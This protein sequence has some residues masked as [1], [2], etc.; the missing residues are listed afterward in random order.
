MV[1]SSARGRAQTDA[2]GRGDDGAGSEESIGEPPSGGD[3]SGRF[4]P[5]VPY[6]F[7]RSVETI[8]R[9]RT[10][11]ITIAGLTFTV[12]QAG[13]TETRPQ[14]VVRALYQ[15]ILRREPDPAG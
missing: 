4:L 7:C 5:G 9:A 10:A 2:Q 1:D 11:H 15:T 13:S 6:G 3:S 12:T 8:P 14:R